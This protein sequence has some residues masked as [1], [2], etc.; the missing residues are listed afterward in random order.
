LTRDAEAARVELHMET[1]LPPRLF[2]A[3]LGAIASPWVKANLDIG[4][5]ASLGYDPAVEIPILAA[6]LGSVHIKDRLLGGGTVPLGT[7]NAM[8]DL[9]FRAIRDAGFNRWFILQTARQGD[10]N[11][12]ELARRNRVVV[13]R[14]MAKAEHSGA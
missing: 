8:L 10:L 5:S 7:G 6:F 2:A 1:D 4:N 14:G 13:E 9:C 11:E 12:V 3:V